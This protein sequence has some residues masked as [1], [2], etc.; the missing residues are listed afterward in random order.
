M[1]VITKTDFSNHFRVLF[2]GLPANADL[3]IIEKQRKK[4]PQKKWEPI[5]LPR[6]NPPEPMAAPKKD[7]HNSSEAE[8]QS[9]VII[10]DI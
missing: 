3:W 9:T 1:A 4:N 7:N 8:P 2:S 6:L 10:F 5:E